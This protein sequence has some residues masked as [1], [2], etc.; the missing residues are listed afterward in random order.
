MVHGTADPEHRLLH[1]ACGTGRESGDLG[2]ELERSVAL[3]EQIGNPPQLWRSLTAW[4]ELGEAAAATRAVDTIDAVIKSLDDHP[5]AAALTN[6]PE[7]RTALALRQ[8]G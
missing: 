6:S 8:A 3:A 1:H 2:G 4:A 5:L 7:R